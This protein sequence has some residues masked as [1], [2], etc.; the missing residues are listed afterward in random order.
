MSLKEEGEYCYETVEERESGQLAR[1]ENKKNKFYCRWIL[2][3][4]RSFIEMFLILHLVIKSR[5]E[6]RICF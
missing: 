6:L 5:S 1:S 4:E 3:D 2:F